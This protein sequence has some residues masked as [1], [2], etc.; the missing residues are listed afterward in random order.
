MEL[1]VKDPY[2]DGN[3]F[4]V[5]IVKWGLF[6]VELVKSPH[7]PR[8][9]QFL[10]AKVFYGNKVVW[11][12]KGNGNNYPGIATLNY[13]YGVCVMVLTNEFGIDEV[14]PLQN[15]VTANSVSTK[16]IISLKRKI[17]TDLG[18]TI[19]WNEREKTVLSVLAERALKQGPEQRVAELR[20]REQREKLAESAR[21]RKCTERQA[22]L[23]RILARP[24]VTIHTAQGMRSG[25]PVV[26]N[27]WER[28]PHKTRCVHVT[29]YENGVIDTPIRFFTVIHAHGNVT[30]GGALAATQPVQEEQQPVRRDTRGSILK[31][32]G[33]KFKVVPVKEKSI[34][35]G[36]V[37]NTDDLRTIH[38]EV[39]NGLHFA[40]PHAAR[41][42]YHA[43]FRLGADIH[44]VA[45]VPSEVL[46][47]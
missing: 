36:I 20:E 13:E 43:V 28:L 40:V 21:L 15:M 4:W 14:I 9:G 45:E 25:I 47:T 12:F 44:T 31:R 5:K 10:V 29:S 22:R 38:S 8:G 41:R 2:Q 1:I 35:V 34:S 37:P 7:A 11:S 16:Q 46:L 39:R 42:G 24:P 3:G 32:M 27:E 30:T 6:T 23:A 33:I 19:N 26:D 18:F 17:A